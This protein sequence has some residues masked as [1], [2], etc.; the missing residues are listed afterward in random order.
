MPVHI[1]FREGDVQHW[2]H[3]PSGR[4]VRTRSADDRLWL[5]HAIVHYLQ[6][7]GDRALLDDAVPF[8]DG[9]VVPAESEDLYFEPSITPEAASVYEH[10]ARALDASLELGPHGLPLMQG[11]DWN[12]GMNRVGIGGRGEIGMA[13]LVSLRP[14]AQLF[15]DRGIHAATPSAANAGRVWRS[16]SSPHWSSTPGTVPGTGG[17]ISTMAL[18]SAPRTTRSAASTRSRRAGL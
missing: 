6:T 1:S 15:A 18:R 5:P 13:R 4:G 10:C 2:W 9:P 3:P 11:G 8:I 16:S 14:A 7:T 17:P 12:D